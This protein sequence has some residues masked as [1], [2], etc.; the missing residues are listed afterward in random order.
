MHC[1]QKGTPFS[2]T[3]QQALEA[4]VEVLHITL[5]LR[6]PVLHK[7]FLSPLMKDNIL[8]IH[9]TTAEHELG[10]KILLRRDSSEAGLQRH[11]KDH[12]YN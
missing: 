8:R 10:A 5:H 9:S 3:Y 1:K 4:L 2:R 11:F 7:R 12:F 6:E